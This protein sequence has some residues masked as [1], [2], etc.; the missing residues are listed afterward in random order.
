VEILTAKNGEPSRDWVNPQHGYLVTARARNRVR[1]WF[2]QQDYAQN[3]QEGRTSL[4]KELTRLGIEQKSQLDQ[5][6]NKYN[7][8]AADDLLAAIGRGDLAVGVVARQIGEPRVPEAKPAV[9]RHR[10]PHKLGLRAGAGDVVVEGVDDLMTQVARCCKPVPYDDIVG[11]VTRGRGVTV[12]R[13]DCP[14]VLHLSPTE[15]ERLIQVRWAGQAAES[16]YPVDVCVVAAD[17]KGLL[18]DISS[19]FADD[20]VDVTGVNTRSDRRTDT[21]TMHFTVE[22]RDTAQL[23]RVLLKVN[24]VPD[25]VQVKRSH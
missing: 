23:D 21:A 20:D 11:F 16:S 19:V 14:N 12:H 18:R 24:Q 1:Q 13:R 8:K 9:T 3:L 25:V 6:A 22:I 15:V 17:R 7:L 5:I 4:D 2:K 10:K